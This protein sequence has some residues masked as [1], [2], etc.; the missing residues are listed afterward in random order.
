MQNLIKMV[1][2][3]LSVSM[4]VGFSFVSVGLKL[5]AMV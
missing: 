4:F 3:W 5:I 2:F 1:P